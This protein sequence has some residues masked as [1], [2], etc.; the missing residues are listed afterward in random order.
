MDKNRLMGV[1]TLYL[2]A[3]FN[4]EKTHQWGLYFVI[5]IMTKT[6]TPAFIGIDYKYT[7]EHQ[8]YR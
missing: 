1:L 2:K 7:N 4:I 6:Y 8:V 5:R 3:D